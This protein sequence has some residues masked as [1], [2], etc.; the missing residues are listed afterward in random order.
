MD[1]VPDTV[2]SSR[3]PDR[4]LIEA[5]QAALQARLNEPVVLIE[6]HI[7]WVLL[8]GD[9]AYK[10]K[11]PVRLPFVDF[12]TLASRRRCC[13]LELQLN[14]RLAPQIYLEVLPVCGSAAAP[15]LGGAGPV[16]DHVVCMRRFA[17]GALLSE[18]L[19]AGRLQ[20]AQV[21][22]LAERLADFQKGAPMA[23]PETPWGTPVLIV[24][25]VH[26]VIESLAPHVPADTLATLRRWLAE[27]SAALAPAWQARRAAGA[28]REGHGDL[29]LANA[30]Q[31][32]DEVLAFD[33][34]E[35]DAALRWIDVANDLAFLTMDLAAHDRSDLTARALDAW[36]QRSGDFY[37]LR[38]LRFYEAGRAL[39]RALVAALRVQQRNAA[40]PA[41]NL[42]TEGKA[43]DAPR[44]NHAL[45]PDYLACALQRM[46]PRPVPRLLITHGLSGCGKSTVALQLLA[47]TGAVRVRS[48]VERKR[49]FG[50]QALQRS[51]DH[52]VDA[53]TPEAT[54]RTFD[55]LA[56][57]AREALLAGESVIVDAAFLRRAERQR[58]AALA[59]ELGVPFAILHCHA[60]E[61]VLRERVA[62]RA[63]AGN[64][65]SEADGA[66]LQRQ[67]ADHDPLD[68]DE[69]ALAIDVA[70]DAA[71]DVAALAARWQGVDAARA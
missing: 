45:E 14:R 11:K 9:R 17:P 29:H 49:L 50:L 36:L 57:V 43:A 13:E 4:T 60:A 59:A 7:S 53:Y 69:R 64:D 70:T 16:I 8:A 41:S 27:Q 35:F 10:L 56:E 65:P 21:A 67:I 38:V 23:A 24:Q 52:R 46:A 26:D 62:A 1:A 71:V 2:A 31:V 33:C 3:P 30:V 22:Q 12:S 39:V 63:A 48:D 42:V 44:T 6:T 66:V 61:P 34:I 19:A 5:L 15:Q 25:T 58:F 68:A 51:T 32:G 18:Q 28:V 37:A 55:R 20:A 54:R 40:A 47:H